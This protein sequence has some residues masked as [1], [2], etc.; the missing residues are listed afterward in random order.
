MKNQFVRTK[1]KRHPKKGSKNEYGQ[2]MDWSLEEKVSNMI[3]RYKSCG[4]SELNSA[5]IAYI[6]NCLENG[7]SIDDELIYD[8]DM[9]SEPEGSFSDSF[10]VGDDGL[11]YYESGKVVEPTSDVLDGLKRN[12]GLYEG[13]LYVNLPACHIPGIKAG[14]NAIEKRLSEKKKKAR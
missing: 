2:P 6:R 8:E 4:E 12:L 7:V 9:L 10:Y 13:G 11:L 5:G 1:L 14:I 3:E